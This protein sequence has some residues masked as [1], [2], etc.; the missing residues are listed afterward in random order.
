[1]LLGLIRFLLRKLVPGGDGPSR[2]LFQSGDRIFF[3]QSGIIQ[4]DPRRVVPSRKMGPHSIPFAINGHIFCIGGP[5]CSLVNF[6]NK[7]ENIIYV[8][9]TVSFRD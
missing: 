6:L 9:I 5:N 4:S 8:F 7:V 1:M 3:F 2:E